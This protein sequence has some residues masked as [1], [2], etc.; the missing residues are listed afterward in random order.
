M[1]SG[2]PTSVDEVTVP[3]SVLTAVEIDTSVNEGEVGREEGDESD[4]DV[5]DKG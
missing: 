1:P 4:V 2:D 5:G 3:E